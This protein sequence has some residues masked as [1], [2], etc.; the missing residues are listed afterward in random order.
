M[1]T[2]QPIGRDA[3]RNNQDPV[4]TNLFSV[5][6]SGPEPQLLYTAVMNVEL[7]PSTPFHARLSVAGRAGRAVAEETPTVTEVS[8]TKEGAG[9]R[10]QWCENAPEKQ[11]QFIT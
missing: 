2:L 9:V 1:T 11:T 3:S 5:S 7:K 6:V 8:G 10:G 4:Q